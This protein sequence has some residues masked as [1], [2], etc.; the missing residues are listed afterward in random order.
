MQMPF[1]IAIFSV[2]F[3]RRCGRAA[4]GLPALVEDR[5]QVIVDGRRGNEECRVRQDK[6]PAPSARSADGKPL[7]A[8]R[9]FG[10]LDGAKRYGVVPDLR[11]HPDFSQYL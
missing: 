4:V 1:P 3:A 9:F 11:Q 2:I 10:R 7:S 6:A 8:H 5:A